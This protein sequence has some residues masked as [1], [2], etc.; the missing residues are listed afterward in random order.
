MVRRVSAAAFAV[1][2]AASFAR[3][4]TG[5]GC[6]GEWGLNEG[7]G[8]VLTDQS[9]SHNDGVLNGATWTTAG[10]Y[11]GGIATSGLSGS[12][13]RISDSTSLRLTSAFTLEGWFYP[14]SVSSAWHDGI[15]KGGNDD[16]FLMPASDRSSLPACGGTFGGANDFVNGS[17]AL[18]V[19][20]WSHVACTYD[21]SAIRIFV[22]G[23]QVGSKARSGAVQQSSGSVTL[24]GDPQ[25][26]QYFAG[27]IDEVRIYSRALTAPEIS[28]DMNAP[29][30]PPVPDENPPSAPGPL[31]VTTNTVSMV[32]LMWSAATDDRGIG[33]YHVERCAGPA[34]SNFSMVGTN[35]VPGFSD[36]G[37]TAATTYRYRV[38]AIDTSSNDGPYDA[39]F[40]VTT[41]A[42]SCTPVPSC[43]DNGNVSPCATPTPTIG[44]DKVRCLTAAQKTGCGG[45]PPVGKVCPDNCWAGCTTGNDCP[46]DG[47]ELFVAPSGQT[48]ALVAMLPCQPNDDGG[49]LCPGADWP[50]AVQAYCPTCPQ[51]AI[52]DYC[53]RAYHMTETGSKQES[54]A[55]SNVVSICG[56]HLWIP[57]EPYR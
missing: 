21:G 28:A 53:V 46:V 48:P 26:G 15:Y 30:A 7:S 6:V 27:R 3:A 47:Y 25:W 12:Y 24:G 5:S 41:P 38:H 37:V 32:S 20:A 2:L 50:I 49:A 36:T 11:S 19:N 54:N 16:Y 29:V 22:N 42:G 4:A 23:V 31:S 17:A 43:S 45:T 35:S 51:L 14:T 55:C 40:N 9:A 56:P 1:A 34:C 10:K 8:T 33:M 57:T 18:P 52:S 39:A 44:W 13:A